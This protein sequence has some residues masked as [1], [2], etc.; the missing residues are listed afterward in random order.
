MIKGESLRRRFGVGLSF[1]VVMSSPRILIGDPLINFFS[2]CLHTKKQSFDIAQDKSYR[3]C[4]SRGLLAGIHAFGSGSP[5]TEFGDDI[6][7]KNCIQP[8]LGH[9]E[10]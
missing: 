4:H 9:P 8:Q 5:T 7:D 2:L 3:F 10:S 1:L 6:A